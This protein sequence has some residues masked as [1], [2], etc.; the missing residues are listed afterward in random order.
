MNKQSK[1]LHAFIHEIEDALNSLKED[2]ADSDTD[3]KSMTEK[4]NVVDTFML[5]ME[6]LQDVQ[7]MT[8]RKSFTGIAHGQ[9]V[10]GNTRYLKSLTAMPIFVNTIKN[11]DGS[12]SPSP[13]CE[14]HIGTVDD[15][16]CVLITPQQISI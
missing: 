6:R 9:A 15:K 11:A 3:K 5:Q 12:L 2:V 1:R 16:P 7:P 10:E 13:V 14:M 4:W 8:S